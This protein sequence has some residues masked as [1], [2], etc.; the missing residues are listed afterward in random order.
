MV[1][2]AMGWS[3]VLIEHKIELRESSKN[4]NSMSAGNEQGPNEREARAQ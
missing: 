3:H 1:A 4:E 2:G